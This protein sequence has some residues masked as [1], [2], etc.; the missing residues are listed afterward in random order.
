M[1]TQSKFLENLNATLK[2]FSQGDF[3]IDLETFAKYKSKK[4]RITIDL[5]LK[6]NADFQEIIN[7]LKNISIGNYSQNMLPDGE[8][9]QFAQMLNQVENNVYFL[10]K[11]VAD[12]AESLTMDDGTTIFPIREDHPELRDALNDMIKRLRKENESYQNK[13]KEL[14]EEGKKLKK[15]AAERKVYLRQLSTFAMQ[16][17][18]GDYSGFVPWTHIDKEL[19]ESL[20][21][22][23]LTHDSACEFLA[24]ISNGD[25][26]KEFYSFGEDNLLAQSLNRTRQVL[27]EQKRLLDE[28]NDN[29]ADRLAKKQ[30]TDAYLVSISGYVSAMAKGDY[31]QV[32]PFK[33]EQKELYEALLQLK[34]TI[35]ETANIAIRAANG[36]YSADIV[37]NDKHDL[38]RS[39]VRQMV[40]AFDTLQKNLKNQVVHLKKQNGELEIQQKELLD[41]NF[42]FESKYDDLV[43]H[44]EASVSEQNELKIN[45]DRLKKRNTVLEIE[46]REV[47]RKN[48]K[49]SKQIASL[50]SEN[51]KLKQTN[52]R[53]LKLIS[54]FITD[55]EKSLTD[56]NESIN[57]YENEQKDKGSGAENTLI[58]KMQ[59]QLTSILKRISSTASDINAKV[60]STTLVIDKIDLSN[61][62]RELDLYWKKFALEKDV[63]LD[64]VIEK[65][66][67]VTIATNET[68]F[69]QIMDHLFRT[70]LS[71][72][73][74][75]AVNCRVFRAENKQYDGE[76]VP[77]EM[78][79]FEVRN[80]VGDSLLNG[81]EMVLEAFQGMY[82]VKDSQYDENSLGLTLLRD[83]ASILKGELHLNSVHGQGNQY[84]FLLPINFNPPEIVP[85]VDETLQLA[86]NANT[87]I[88]MEEDTQCVDR[89]TK[90]VQ[91]MGFTCL[92][93]SSA[94]EALEKSQ[95]WNLNGVLLGL[96]W[97]DKKGKDLISLIQKKS[98]PKRVPFYSI[99]DNE[100]LVRDW[101]DVL[102]GNLK[103]STTMRDVKEAMVRM[104]SYGNAPWLNIRVV[105]FDK[106]PNQTMEKV[107]REINKEADFVNVI[108]LSNASG[109]GFNL[110]L[111][112]LGIVD[113]PID[114]LAEKIK[115]CQRSTPGC[116]MVIFTQEK[117]SYKQQTF[118]KQIADISFWGNDSFSDNALDESI[119]MINHTRDLD[120]MERQELL[121]DFFDQRARILNGKQMLMIADDVSQTMALRKKLNMLGI[122]IK[123]NVQ[124][125]HIKEALEDQP[126]WD[127]ILMDLI[128]RKS[129][130]RDA[131]SVIKKEKE[132]AEIPVIM[133]DNHAAKGNKEYWFS[134]GVQEYF[135]K[136]MDFQSLVSTIRV[137]IHLR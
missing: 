6:C 1:W 27:I 104:E 95:K 22:V 93:C 108:D 11:D 37:L 9:N 41:Y 116:P 83:Q 84:L 105:Y 51:E 33:N 13:L 76:A 115:N 89:F 99:V 113:D 65:S 61:Y 58:S 130:T 64:I 60:D 52:K 69:S 50:T 42:K 136:P 70:T 49:L 17:A 55:L 85:E 80:T 44:Y 28:A 4:Y 72:A 59:K 14:L 119:R 25:Y 57:S 94:D 23:K 120:F 127:L 135:A 31:S 2:S 118:F 3:K 88:I 82:A 86:Q 75:G 30:A 66:A 101:Q 132:L 24:R 12:M 26:S 126:H 100:N 81:Y 79:G 34:D 62:F 7:N 133:M 20:N 110:L 128:E 77:R 74:K 112:D 96:K 131:V 106:K 46:N 18:R 107:V 134:Q 117:P 53:N 78:I 121:A 43:K 73:G 125:K 92:P 38:L 122:E 40:Q 71:N 114:V 39:A 68:R 35:T 67:S 102:I 103:K 29:A 32:A 45:N 98:Y 5:L 90:T 91:D 15:T 109:T 124:G 97:I 56:C 123:V 47:G 63:D 10:T 137:L 19:A 48:T 111:L 21:Q 87:L 129:N 16:I 36:D 54:T 8:Q